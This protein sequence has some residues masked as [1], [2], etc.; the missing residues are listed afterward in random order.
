MVPNIINFK[1]HLEN[2]LRCSFRIYITISILKDMT[3]GKILRSIFSFSLNW[4]LTYI[5]V[6]LPLGGYGSLLQ[7]S[8]TSLHVR[9]CFITTHT[10]LLFLSDNNFRYKFA[11][12]FFHEGHNLQYLCNGCWGLCWQIT[13]TSDWVCVCV[14]VLLGSSLILSLQMGAI[15]I[16]QLGLGC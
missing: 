6:K 14:R 4:Q 8:N 9:S 3:E 12:R 2:A 15:A 13:R 16:L 10:S 5:T 11:L 7:Q 1:K